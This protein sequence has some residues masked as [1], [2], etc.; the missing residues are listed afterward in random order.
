[1]VIIKYCSCIIQSSTLLVL[2]LYCL[3]CI[4]FAPCMSPMPTKYIPLACRRA[5]KGNAEQIPKQPA[6]WCRSL[7]HSCPFIHPPLSCLVGHPLPFHPSLWCNAQ[8]FTCG[9]CSKYNTGH[10]LGVREVS[11]GKAIWF[12][13][14]WYIYTKVTSYAISKFI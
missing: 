2:V 6:C 5:L 3:L 14:F 13:D 7:K 1:M 4:P 8:A 12:W 9:L 10:C 11:S